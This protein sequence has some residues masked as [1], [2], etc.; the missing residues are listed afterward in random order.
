MSPAPPSCRIE[1]EEWD[2]YIIPSKT[3]SDK[4]KVS[5]TFSFLKSRMSSTR[6]KNK[7]RETKEQGEVNHKTR[8]KVLNKSPECLTAFPAPALMFT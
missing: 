4:Y 5:R 6:N 7:V 8:K 3:E 1:E 2:R